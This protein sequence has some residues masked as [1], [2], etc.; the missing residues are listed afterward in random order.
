MRTTE[1]AQGI[2]WV[3]AIDWDVRDFHGYSTNRGTTYNAFL[4]IDDKITLFDTVKRSHLDDLLNHV[5]AIIDPAKIDY[6]VVNHVE[7]DHSGALP[8]MMEIIKPE[9]LICSPA[10]HKAI[11]DHFHREDWPFEIVKTG[12]EISL[13]KRTI[14]FI[15]TRMLHWPDSMFSYLKEDGILFSSD[16]F[17]EHYASSERFDDEAPLADVMNEAAKYYANILYLYSPLIR[18]LLK[19]VGEMNL[20]I[21]MIAPDHGVI[22]RSH[23]DTILKAYDRWSRNIADRKALVIYDTMWHSTEKM[24]KAV[25]EGLEE[26]GV[27]TSMINLKH[28]HRSDVMTQV[29]GARA[30]VLGS[31][32]LNNG[33]LPR[34][35]GFLSYMR[36]LKPS[37][38][39]C[40]AFGSFGWSGEAVNLLNT[41]L[42]EMKLDVIEE[43]IRHKYVPAEAQL[44]ECREMGKRIG[45]AVVNSND[46]DGE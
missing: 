17:G 2:H 5:R 33:I 31:A 28:H 3:G 43:G 1:L 45:L 14:Q 7:M 9:K 25:A 11:V 30:I 19:Q 44:R 23:I 15:E 41:A 18:K 16:A 20:D 42:H 6:L 37:G 35:A 27:H 32:T 10:G 39:F 40:A 22:W 34:M 36:G 13:G 4:V 26:A 8:Q 12:D 21:R 29:L 24:A 46:G 38:K